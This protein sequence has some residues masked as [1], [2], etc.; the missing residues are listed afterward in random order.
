[1]SVRELTKEESEALVKDLQDVLAKH[2]AEMSV[3]SNINL[4]KRIEETNDT[5]NLEKETNSETEEGG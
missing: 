1:M 3:T 2:G 4:L 5:E